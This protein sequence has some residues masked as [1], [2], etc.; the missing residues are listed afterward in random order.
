MKNPIVEF[1]G[2]KLVELVQH[3]ILHSCNTRPRHGGIG[4]PCGIGFSKST[5]KLITHVALVVALVYWFRRS[6]RLPGIGCGIGVL[7][8]TVSSTSSSSSG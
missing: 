8:Q 5:Q 4:F 7:V 2:L 3:G 6:P 1:L